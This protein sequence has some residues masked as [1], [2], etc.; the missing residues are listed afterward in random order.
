MAG[1]RNG[2]RR[3]EWIQHD[4]RSIA[5]D[6]FSPSFPLRSAKRQNCRDPEWGRA[7]TCARPY[8][9][10]RF[11]LLHLLAGIEAI[12]ERFRYFRQ[13]RDSYTGAVITGAATP[14]KR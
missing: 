6:R 9:A 4:A 13:K 5:P 11:P 3:L 12:A 14:P 10:W 8:P 1:R 7:A 2:W